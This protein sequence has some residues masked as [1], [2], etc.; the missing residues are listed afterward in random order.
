[1]FEIRKKLMSQ[2]TVNPFIGV[3]V[4][5]ENDIG[6]ISSNKQ[7]SQRTHAVL[8]LPRSIT[9]TLQLKA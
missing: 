1:M 8:L 6:C 7:Q 4:E 9:N 2:F 5:V 3:A